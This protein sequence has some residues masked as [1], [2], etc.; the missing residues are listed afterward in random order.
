MVATVCGVVE[1]VN[2]L[3]YVRALRA[4]F[5][6][7]TVISFFFFHFYQTKFSEADEFVI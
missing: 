6:I 1:R 5:C 3:V 4:R 2:K 7:S